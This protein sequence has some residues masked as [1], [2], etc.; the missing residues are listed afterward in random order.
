MR[1]A[2]LKPWEA[3]LSLNRDGGGVEE[4]EGRWEAGEGTGREEQGEIVVSM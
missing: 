2:L 3:F 4:D 1:L